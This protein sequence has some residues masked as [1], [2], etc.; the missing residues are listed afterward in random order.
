MQKGDRNRPGFE[1][2]QLRG[3]RSVFTPAACEDFGA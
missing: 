2:T 3:D 1:I